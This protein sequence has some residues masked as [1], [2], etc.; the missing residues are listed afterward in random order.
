VRSPPHATGVATYLPEGAEFVASA[1]ASLDEFR[2]VV[3][4][5]GCL[6]L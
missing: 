4:V 6:G 1:P 3:P 5:Q 2:G